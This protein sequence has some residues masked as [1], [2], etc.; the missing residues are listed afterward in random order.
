[1]TKLLWR[2]ALTQTGKRF[3]LAAVA[4]AMALVS[5]VGQAQAQ[6]ELNIYNWGEYINPAVLQ[7]FEEETGIKVNLDVYGSNEEMLAKVQTGATGYDLVFPSVHMHDIMA[8]LD[9]LHKTNINEYEGFKNIEPSF[10][11]AKSDP[12]GEYCLPYAWG[13]VGIVYNREVLG[14]DITGWRDL[15]QTVRE[16]DLKFTLL[17][18]MRE[19]ISV[20]LMMNGNSVNSTDPQELQEAAETIIAMKPYV[21]AFTYEARP[22]VEAGDV[23]AGHFFVGAMVDVFREPEKLG[24]VIPEEGAT[25]YQE[26]I[27]VLKSSPNKENAIKFLEFYTQPEVAA[28]NIEQ[29]TNGTPN[30]PA[31]SM[32][33]EHIANSEEINPPADVMERLQIFVDL[34]ADIRKFDRVWTT[35]KTAQ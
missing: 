24:Y 1:M 20:G 3:G 21:A 32:T 13:S 35:I 28:L 8:K 34:G 15:I 25:M 7:K 27:C 12:N 23:A 31:R 4:G 30:K 29:Q 17:D 19:V 14:K 9:L 2:K 6:G 10:L 5:G 11:R 16:K 33:A 22:I 18:D 26:D